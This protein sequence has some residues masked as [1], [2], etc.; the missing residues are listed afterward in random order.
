MGQQANEAAAG[1]TQHIIGDAWCDALAHASPFWDGVVKG[2]FREKTNGGLLLQF[3][4]KLI[5]NATQ[6]FIPMAGG[7]VGIT[8]SVQNQYGQLNWKAFYLSINFTLFDEV[9]SN[10]DDDKIKYLAKKIKGALAD[11]NRT[12][13]SSTYLGTYDSM[14]GTQSSNPLNFDGLEDVCVASGSS[15]AG[16]TDTDYTD[17]T[18]AY[19]PFISTDTQPVYGTLNRMINTVKGRVQVSEFAPEK[20]FATMGGDVFSVFQNYVQG[21]QIFGAFLNTS[22]KYSVGFE[23]FTVNDVDFYQ[24]SYV[25][26]AGVGASNNRI[27]IVPMDVFKFHYKFGFDSE[28]PFD[29][30]DLRI[31][32]QPIVTTQKYIVGNW[33]CYDR[34]L[35][36]VNKSIKI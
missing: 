31:P 30:E 28:S 9:V 16:L 8:P 24:D 3:P 22:K 1:I 4:I 18:S 11:A 13:A 6:G 12:M 5:P 15:Y 26:G 10:G 33:V 32:D 2:E 20:Y 27:F 7:K 23:G 36:A 34:R 17:D 25:G 35:I 21:S 14:G 19:L 29:V